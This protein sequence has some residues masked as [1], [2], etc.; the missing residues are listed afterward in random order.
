MIKHSVTAASHAAARPLSL[1]P[2]PQ[3]VSPGRAGRLPSP[4]ASPAAG[5]APRRGAAPAAA[6][7]AAR[8]APGPGLSASQRREPSA[9]QRPP[10]ELA[11]TGSSPISPSCPVWPARPPSRMLPQSGLPAR[12]GS[13]RAP[14]RRDARPPPGACPAPLR[15]GP[16][17]RLRPRAAGRVPSRGRPSGHLWRSSARL[18]VP[19]RGPQRRDGA[20][21]PPL[22]AR[23]A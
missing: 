14:P 5:P 3:P 7:R 22:V 20:S 4:R 9:G 1:R 23:S 10:A 15:R 18:P 8:A 17:R 16:G 13:A 2:E 21:R 11:E 19:R 6:T 12:A